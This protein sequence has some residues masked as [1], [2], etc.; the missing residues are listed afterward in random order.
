MPDL[1]FLEEYAQREK[2]IAIGEVGLDYYWDKSYIDQQKEVFCQQI[3]LAK[4][5]LF[6]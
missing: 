3:E 1:S 6:P 2:V 5:F 4:N